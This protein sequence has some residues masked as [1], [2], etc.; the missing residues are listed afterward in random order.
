MV[1]GFLGYGLVVVFGLV[2]LLDIYIHIF[3]YVFLRGIFLVRS[4]F[5]FFFL[6]IQNTSIYVSYDNR[7]FLNIWIYMFLFFFF[8]VDIQTVG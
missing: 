2:G 4:V 5:W 8:G 7:Q 6:D 1:C 3:I